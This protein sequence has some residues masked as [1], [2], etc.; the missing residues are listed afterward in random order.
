MRH[1]RISDLIRRSAGALLLLGSLGVSS[2]TLTRAEDA[3]CATPAPACTPQCSDD[4]YKRAGERL[5]QQ[6][7]QMGSQ[8]CG[9]AQCATAA[10]GCA[11]AGHVFNT[12]VDERPHQHRHLDFR[13]TGSGADGSDHVLESS[14]SFAESQS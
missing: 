13:R 10:P 5:A 14:E 7:Q 11:N 12:A 2:D 4:V 6:L 3:N 1:G 8:P 9:Q